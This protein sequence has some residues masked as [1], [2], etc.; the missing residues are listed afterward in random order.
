MCFDAGSVYQGMGYGTWSLGGSVPIE[1]V[2]VFRDHAA[3]MDRRLRI[4]RDLCTALGEIHRHPWV[5]AR[6]IARTGI[7]HGDIK[8]DNIMVRRDDS[9][10]LN[11]FLTAAGDGR[12]GPT[13]DSFT[14]V[15]GTFGYITDNRSAPPG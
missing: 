8:P 10:V 9:A 11:D 13:G 5:D 12:W 6:G 3:S 15:T 7:V 2:L 4:A 14:G 1:R